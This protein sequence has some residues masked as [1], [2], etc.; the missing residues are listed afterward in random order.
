[1]TAEPSALEARLKKIAAILVEE[2]IASFL[3]F[4]FGVTLEKEAQT[5][6]SVRTSPNG[7]ADLPGYLVG[8]APHADP[9]SLAR[10]AQRIID[11]V[12]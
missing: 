5:I 9:A 8:A 6:E 10:A 3:P 4:E 2:S 11:E 12:D 7:A 1:M